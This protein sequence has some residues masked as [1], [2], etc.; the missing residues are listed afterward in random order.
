MLN[1]HS[2]NRLMLLL[3]KVGTN[4]KFAAPILTMNSIPLLVRMLS[5]VGLAIVENKLLYCFTSS[6]NSWEVIAKFNHN[7]NSKEDYDVKDEGK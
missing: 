4:P 2:N 3:C 7:C 5:L 1:K 6:T